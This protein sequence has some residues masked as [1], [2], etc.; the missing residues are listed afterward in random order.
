MPRFVL[1]RH[2]CPPEFEKPSHWDFMLESDGVLRTWELRQLP[3]TWARVWGENCT[4]KAVPLVQLADHRLAYL[5]FEGPLSGD[6]GRVA[7]WDYGTYQVFDA[8]THRLEI[9][10]AGQ[11][12]TGVVC[13]MR[14][15]EGW[16]LNPRD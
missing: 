13:L 2:E 4:D 3:Q 5:D 16:L 7:R 10:L 9:R 8:S 1:L 15:D 6:R 11:R 12:L 14:D